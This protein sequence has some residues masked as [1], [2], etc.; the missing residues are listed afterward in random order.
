MRPF[1]MTFVSQKAEPTRELTRH[2]LM[3][4]LTWIGS[5]GKC[6]VSGNG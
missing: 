6:L 3:K 5:G 4:E 1:T 2:I